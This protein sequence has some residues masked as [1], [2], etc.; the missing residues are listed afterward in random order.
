M[1]KTIKVILPQIIAMYIT[2]I[3]GRIVIVFGDVQ[4]KYINVWTLKHQ[5]IY[6]LIKGLIQGM[7]IGTISLSIIL[8]ILKILKDKEIY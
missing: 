1:L 4:Q 7:I 8:I 5:I 2:W 6:A 3:L